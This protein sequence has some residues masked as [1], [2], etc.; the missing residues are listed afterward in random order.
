ME[1]VPYDYQDTGKTATY[2]TKD[3][4]SLSEY[5]N[6][7]FDRLIPYVQTLTETGQITEYGI[8]DDE[9]KTYSEEGTV[10]ELRLGR[11]IS[12]LRDQRPLGHCIARALQLL[13]QVPASN[14]FVSNVC[15]VKFSEIRSTQRTSTGKIVTVRPGLPSADSSLQDNA[16][17]AMTELLFYDAIAVGSPKLLISD[18]PIDGRKSSLEQYIEFMRRMAA[19]FGDNPGRDV[20]SIR[21]SGLSGI[22]NKRDREIC[23]DT[24][25]EIRISPGV[26]GQVQTIVQDMFRIQYEHTKA[27][28]DIIRMLFDIRRD[29]NGRTSI[30]LS[31]RIIKLGFPEI[32][33]INH[34]ARELLMKYYSNCEARYVQGMAVVV[35]SKRQGE[36]Q[37]TQQ[38][39]VQ[40]AQAKAQAKAEPK[41]KAQPK[42][43]AQAKSDIIQAH[44]QLLTQHRQQLQRIAQSGTQPLK[45]L[46]TTLLNYVT[47]LPSSPIIPEYAYLMIS[48]LGIPH[49]TDNTRV[50]REHL[51]RFQYIPQ[52]IDRW[53]REKQMMDR[54][55]TRIFFTNNQNVPFYFFS[56]L[57]NNPFTDPRD[58][59]KVWATVSSYYLYQLAVYRN[60]APLATS[61]KDGKKLTEAQKSIISDWL[62]NPS[63]DFRIYQRRAM[64]RGNLLKFVYPSPSDPKNMRA[65]LLCSTINR[66]LV[67]ADK[68]PYWGIGKDIN[69][70]PST[71]PSPFNDG[72][73]LGKILMELR[74]QLFTSSRSQID[75]FINGDAT[76]PSTSVNSSFLTN[77]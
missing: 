43:H 51:L 59:T 23:G 62:Q 38:T 52:E 2:Q 65:I 25:T 53:N 22:K 54:N 6:K 67:F 15:N 49:D 41:E 14:E 13:Q 44:Q 45:R 36:A 47:K 27:C 77:I 8:S 18:R 3:G 5:F 37:Q 40:Q 42:A 7:L 75:Q 39:Q 35:Q 56:Y 68:D 12:N 58:S 72:N 66:E 21:S 24:K 29:S 61:L 74:T 31:E 9:K 11:L 63:A 20:S 4:E 76:K 46:A 70:D 57:S 19:L 71:I 16:G 26:A 1:F 28:S 10:K 60:D 69:K 48:Y 50:I 17:L 32:E 34:A 55:L 64:Y 73:H 30:S 33:R